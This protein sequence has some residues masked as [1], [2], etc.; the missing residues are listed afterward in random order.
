[1]E[2]TWKLLESQKIILRKPEPEDL[3]FLYTIENNPEYWFVSDSRSPFSKWQL[4]Q[5]IENTIYDIYT[6]KE[7]RLIVE[8]KASKKIVGLVDL[9]E[10][11]P[12]H[13]RIGVGVLIAEQNRKQG[14]AAQCISM[15]IE[16]CFKVLEINQIWCN[17][18]VDNEISIRLFE[19]AGFANTGLLKQWKIQNGKFKDVLFYQLFNSIKI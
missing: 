19:N 3:D 1:M 7:L 13:K 15:I 10:F 5:H 9:F 4:K 6:N 17:I 8:D 12:F 14:I 18:D 11:E 16:Y 2:K